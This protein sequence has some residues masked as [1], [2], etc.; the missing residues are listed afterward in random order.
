MLKIHQ[1]AQLTHL[2][3]RST[4]S[5]A[6]AIASQL[7]SPNGGRDALLAKHDNDVVIVSAVRTAL[8]RGKK[9]GFKVSH[10]FRRLVTLKS[11]RVADG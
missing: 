9:G 10:P 2:H 11:A 3:Y 1:R 5:R 8:T 7:V 4:L 6:S